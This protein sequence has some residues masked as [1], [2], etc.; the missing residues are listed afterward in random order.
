MSEKKDI[1]EEYAAVKV[2]AKNA[3]IDFSYD[4]RSKAPPQ[5]EPMFTRLINSEACAWFFIGM[6]FE[7]LGLA[8]QFIIQG[9]SYPILDV[10]VG[11]GI[12]AVLLYHQRQKRKKPFLYEETVC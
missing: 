4:I 11:C 10:I 3:A 2:A 6:G 5:I 8:L 9:T 12:G 1:S 7:A